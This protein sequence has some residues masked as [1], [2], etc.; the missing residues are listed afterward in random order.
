MDATEYYD[1]EEFGDDW[2]SFDPDRFSF[3]LTG[4]IEYTEEYYLNDIRFYHKL[5][6]C[7]LKEETVSVDKIKNY[8]AHIDEN[9][10][11][12]DELRERIARRKSFPLPTRAD[13]K[14]KACGD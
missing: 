4:D 9:E 14:P 1:D 7:A 12:L 11:G 3:S 6:N 5:I 2:L 8:M 10:A 13:V